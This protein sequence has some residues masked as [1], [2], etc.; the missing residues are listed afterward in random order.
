LQL[1]FIRHHLVVLAKMEAVAGSFLERAEQVVP[2]Q[3]FALERR[4]PRLTLTAR[5]GQ[6]PP[7][8]QA[9]AK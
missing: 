7:P 6:R 4:A 8:P 3:Q 1:S 9:G 2:D 5:H